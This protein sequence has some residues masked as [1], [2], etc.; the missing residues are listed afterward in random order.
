MKAFFVFISFVIEVAIPIIAVPVVPLVI[1]NCTT[2]ESVLIGIGISIFVAVWVLTDKTVRNFNKLEKI[3]NKAITG[4]EKNDKYITK[5][6]ENTQDHVARIETILRFEKQIEGIQSVYFRRLIYSKLINVL[7]KFKEDE[8]GLFD[9]YIETNPYSIETYGVEGIKLTKTKVFA[10]SSIKDYWD[11]SEFVTDYLK[12]QYDM[13]SNRSIIIKRIFVGDKDKLYHLREMMK[14]QYDHGIQVFYIEADSEYCPNEWLQE[15]FLIQ[16][17]M[18][19]V[20]LKATT[21]GADSQSQEIITTRP[22]I[23]NGKIALFDTMIH[24]AK[25]WSVTPI[26]DNQSFL[27]FPKVF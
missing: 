11:R 10:V 14:D 13:I 5:G 25:D 16:D 20:D 1:N 12:A 26:K 3:E 22:S 17:D 23:V 19:I 7:E 15:D 6:F 4:I 8:A 18:L 21:H 24:N 27:G 9:G 2:A